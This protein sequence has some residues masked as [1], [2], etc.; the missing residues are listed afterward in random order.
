MKV[1]NTLKQRGY[2]L[3]KPREEILKV[4]KEYPL[5]V[6]EI[7]Q[8]LKK[9]Q[10]SIDVASIYRSLELFMTMGFIQAID[11]GEGKKRYERIEKNNHHHHLICDN[12]GT[13]KDVTV[14]EDTIMRAI[15][16]RSHFKIERHSL[17]FFGLCARCQ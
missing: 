10:I 6:Q 16:S 8:A 13:I 7:A 1:I 14:K 2:R 11:L 17:E 9:R 5:S 15:K 4:L 3:T 12:C